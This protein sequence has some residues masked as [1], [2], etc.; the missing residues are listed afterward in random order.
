MLAKKRRATTDRNEGSTGVPSARRG[1]RR[2]MDPSLQGLLVM[3]LGAAIVWQADRIGGHF[4][5]DPWLA[6]TTGVFISASGLVIQR[7][8]RR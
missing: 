5:V 6:A 8:G 3:F 4:H 7:R 2:Q 1:S